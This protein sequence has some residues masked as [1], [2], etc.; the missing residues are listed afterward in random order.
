MADAPVL[1]ATDEA[2]LMRLLTEG[3]IA[4][5]V[6]PEEL[7]GLSLATSLQADLG[8]DSYQLTNVA[9]YLEEAFLLRFT[10]VDWVLD[11]ADRDE[12]AYTVA[13]LFHFIRA[14]LSA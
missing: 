5:G 4:A 7:A 9:R 11:E 12:D 10:L 1:P 3:L 6:K 8:V 2:T 13:S 14:Q